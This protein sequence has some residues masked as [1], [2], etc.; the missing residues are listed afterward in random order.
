M[1][2]MMMMLVVVLIGIVCLSYCHGGLSLCQEHEKGKPEH[3]REAQVIQHQVHY[4]F[5]RVEFVNHRLSRRRKE[6]PV[7]YHSLRNRT[8]QHRSDEIRSD[9][10]RSEQN[11]NRTE[12]KITQQTDQI[13]TKQRQV[14]TLGLEHIV[15]DY[16]PRRKHYKY[17]I[18]N[19]LNRW[20][21]I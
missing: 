10:M 19:D 6:D 13:R 9:E 20:E 7:Q 15:S 5:I 18:K 11:R 16:K 8:K 14:R 17:I 12:Q 21:E 2:I 4:L 1:L 3:S